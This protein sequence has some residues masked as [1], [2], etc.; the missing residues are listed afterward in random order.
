MLPRVRAHS[1][2][3]KTSRSCCFKW[4]HSGWFKLQSAYDYDLETVHNMVM[5]MI[6]MNLIIVCLHEQLKVF[7]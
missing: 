7:K 6:I 4:P 1:M 5:V 2:E 3:G